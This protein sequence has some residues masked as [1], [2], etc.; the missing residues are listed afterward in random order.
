MDL[1][2]F[3]A[4]AALGSLGTVLVQGMYKKLK[5]PKKEPEVSEL[6]E[7][8]PENELGPGVF[9]EEWI[10]VEKTLNE[11]DRRRF[12]TCMRSMEHFMRNC[13]DMEAVDTIGR[14][15]LAIMAGR[16]SYCGHEN[17]IPMTLSLGLVGVSC[18]I[19]VDQIRKGAGNNIHRKLGLEAISKI[20]RLLLREYKEECAVNN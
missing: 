6:T 17:R 10:K 14:Y 18:D 12:R 19:I 13:N 3:A 2:Y 20:S 7:N 9:Y 16:L 4:G 11:F 1:A 5:A 15:L 8:K